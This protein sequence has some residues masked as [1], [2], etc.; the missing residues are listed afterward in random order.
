MLNKTTSEIE[1]SSSEDE[2]S[3]K[4]L[5]EATD[6][7]FLK[8]TLFSNPNKKET[9]ESNEKCSSS[10]TKSLRQKVQED[11][12][13]YNFGVTATFKTYVAKKLDTLLERTIKL[14]D[15]ETISKVV[16]IVENKEKS[17]NNCGIKL[18]SSSKNLLS[19]DEEII[20]ETKSH[21]K[22]K[23]MSKEV[24]DISQFLEAAVDPEK[25]LSM[26][27]TEAWTDRHK[28]SVFKYK[29]LKNGTLIEKK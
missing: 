6:I 1:S 10:N 17:H 16:T 24:T 21:K 22:R 3:I 11:D 26:I 7:V 23:K 20:R 12:N 15:E 8:S 4:A 13:F 28:G 14:D 5:K 29:K 2:I 27:E 25:I 18:L 9:S 19:T